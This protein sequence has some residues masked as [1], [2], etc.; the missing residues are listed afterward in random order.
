MSP[1]FKI[2]TVTVSERGF[3]YRTHRLT[4]WLNGRRIREQFRNRDEA[5]GRKNALEVEASNAVSGTRARVTRLS[6]TQLAEAESAFARLG[7][8]SLSEAVGWYLANYRPPQVATPIG[9]A[10]TQFLAD[11]ANH[12]RAI[13]LRG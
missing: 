8:R 4:G 1:G 10:T 6:E 9:T 11:R 5:E 2:K 12:A 3:T 13:V 7:A